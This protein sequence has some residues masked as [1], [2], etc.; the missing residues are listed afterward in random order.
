MDKRLIGLKDGVLV[1]HK[2]EAKFNKAVTEILPELL[3]DTK[4]DLQEAHGIHPKINKRNS[5]MPP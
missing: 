1:K 3:K 5:E 2:V 4:L